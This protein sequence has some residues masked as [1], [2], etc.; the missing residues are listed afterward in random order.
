MT[1]AGTNPCV[2][3]MVQDAIANDPNKTSGLPRTT[4]ERARVW[5]DRANMLLGR[6]K[7]TSSLRLGSFDEFLCSFD[8][9]AGTLDFWDGDVVKDSKGRVGVVKCV[10]IAPAVYGGGHASVLFP[11]GKVESVK[12]DEMT[13]SE[14][15]DEFLA[16]ARAKLRAECRCPLSDEAVYGSSDD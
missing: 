9:Y 3:Q 4:L 11:N 12:W 2:A 6:A 8:S 14:I 10:Q 5:Y 1:R 13:H 15:P 7:I 16:I